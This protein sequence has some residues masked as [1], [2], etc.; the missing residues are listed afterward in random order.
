MTPSPAWYG[1]IIDRTANASIE[2]TP[3]I[4]AS[5]WTQR[6]ARPPTP[7]IARREDDRLFDEMVTEH[8]AS[9]CAEHAALDADLAAID[10]GDLTR[11]PGLIAPL[12]NHIDREENGL[13]PRPWPTWTTPSGTPLNNPNSW[14][15]RMLGVGRRHEHHPKTEWRWRVRH[16]GNGGRTH[17]PLRRTLDRSFDP[18]P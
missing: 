13:S 12:H 6:D 16:F 11:V 18:C 2:P 10:A 4:N 7:P 3:T 1:L 14:A 15:T 9:L 8:G 5:A 17:H